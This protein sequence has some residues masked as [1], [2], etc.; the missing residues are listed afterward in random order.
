VAAVAR[1]LADMSTPPRLDL[2]AIDAALSPL[3]E[4]GQM[5][6]CAMVELEVL[7]SSR[8]PDDYLRRHQ[9]LRDGFEMVD[10][11]TD[12]LD[13]APRG[14][15]LTFDRGGAS[16]TRG[17]QMPTYVSTGLT[18]SAPA[19]CGNAVHS[20]TATEAEHPAVPTTALTA[21]PNTRLPSAPVKVANYGC[22]TSRTFGVLA[23]VQ[24]RLGNR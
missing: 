2:P 10:E 16:T 11:E 23:T 20:V 9:Q 1:Y 3:I 14:A 8:T 21:A 5:A 17:T 15:A 12:L 24:D 22:R 19:G 4:A 18:S 6:T 13:L 7:F